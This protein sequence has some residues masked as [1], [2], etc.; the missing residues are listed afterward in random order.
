[1]VFKPVLRG[2]LLVLP[3]LLLA[4]C[5]T[6]GEG[7]KIETLKIKDSVAYQDVLT[8]PVPMFQCLRYNF[9]ALGTFTDGTSADYG[10]RASTVWTSSNPAAAQV[11]NG[12]IQLP[13]NATSAYAKGTVIPV[14]L[15]P[16]TITVNYVGRTDSINIMVVGAPK[17][18]TLIP[19]APIS[20]RV[21]Y[22][23]GT[24]AALTIAPRTVQ[25]YTALAEL[26][27][28][29]VTRTTD[30]TSAGIWS[31]V[32]AVTPPVRPNAN[33][34]N[35]TNDAVELITGTTSSF[36]AKPLN[37]PTNP[38]TNSAVTIQADFNSIAG[39]C[40][41]PKTTTLTVANFD[42]DPNSVPFPIKLSSEYDDGT[43]PVPALIVRTTDRLK[44][45]ANLKTANGVKSTQDISELGVSGDGTTGITTFNLPVIPSS[46]VPPST[47]PLSDL[48][49]FSYTT[50]GVLNL[51]YAVSSSTSTTADDSNSRQFSAKFI[52]VPGTPTTNGS[53]P[54][55]QVSVPS[56]TITRLTRNATLQSITICASNANTPQNSCVTSPAVST[57]IGVP[58]FLQYGEDEARVRLKAVGSFLLADGS[59]TSQDISRTVTWTSSNSSIISI[60]NGSL[61]PITAG[62]AGSSVAGAVTVSA[63]F[64]D[65]VTLAVT[66]SNTLTLLA[67]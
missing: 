67:Q 33:A 25:T 29:G 57:T 66:T 62:L 31:V 32:G 30:I 24:S 13:N 52:T 49:V 37:D 63:T 14:G 48:T 64:T 34:A 45:L 55:D 65:P 2:V 53:T 61:S 5:N 15:G 19:N 42:T 8:Q 4:A 9:S 47:T 28:A 58:R 46:T 20:P 50:S 40:G 43:N 17:S 16:A 56:N 6:V 54:P 35:L 36:R 11:S 23:P 3:L 51:I 7:N 22:T 59:I 1:M 60:V 21:A 27:A 18:I 38:V 26:V 44:A 12:D 10:T 41:A 39:A